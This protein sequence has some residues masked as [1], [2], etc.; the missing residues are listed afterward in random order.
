MKRLIAAVIIIFVSPVVKAEKFPIDQVCK[1]FEQCRDD[2]VQVD[3]AGHTIELHTHDK[4]GLDLGYSKLHVELQRI[5]DRGDIALHIGPI[6][7]PRLV[8][9]TKAFALNN[10][11]ITI[12]T[13]HDKQVEIQCMSLDIN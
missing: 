7:E 11:H 9:L 12:I 2:N 13:A 10:K 4:I 8:S 3:V 5:S 1:I 6:G